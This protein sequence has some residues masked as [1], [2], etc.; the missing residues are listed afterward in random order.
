VNFLA[1][2]KKILSLVAL[3]LLKSRGNS[4]REL[5]SAADNKRRYAPE[6]SLMRQNA[7]SK[8]IDEPSEN[9]S[10]RWFHRNAAQ[11]LK[12]IALV[13][14]GLNLRPE[15]ME[16][17]IAILTDTG[18]DALNLSLRGHGQNYSRQDGSNDAK[19][20]L[21]ALKS[22]SYEL[23]RDEIVAAYHIAKLKSTHNSVPLFFVGF[24]CGALMGVDLLA[25]M[26]DVEFD[27]MVLFAP[28]LKIHS[29]YQ[30]VRVL[31]PF[32]GLTVPNFSIKSYRANDGTPIAAYNALLDS[33]EHLDNNLNLKINVPALIFIDKRDEFVSFAELKKLVEN[34]NLD[35]W[36][37]HVVKKK[38]GGEPG[39]IHHLII[40][41]A[42][43]GH[44][45]W[46]EITDVMLKHLLVL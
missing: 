33:M 16:S 34:E 20:R 36:K 46:R 13:I 24:S 22:V 44:A 37:F 5:R 6:K 29:R 4:S 43:T 18:V 23:W 26:S 8:S 41:E 14:H 39:K 15:K 17:I 30:I 38:A 11:E 3:T 25:S 42:S 28:G 9:P 19:A 40:D 45:A 31:A 7:Q 1:N 21:N 10:V 27:R 2:S 32:P 12:G 35:Q